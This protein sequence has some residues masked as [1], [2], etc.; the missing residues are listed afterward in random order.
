MSEGTPEKAFV[1]AMAAATAGKD[2]I[3]LEDSKESNLALKAAIV[4]DQTTIEPGQAARVVDGDENGYI[5]LYVPATITIDLGSAQTITSWRLAN[6]GTN[7]GLSDFTIKASI[8]GKEY[9][10]IASVE[11]NSDVIVNGTIAEPAAY[12]YYQLEC[13]KNYGS[14]GDIRELELNGHKQI[15]YPAGVKAD[16]QRPAA[17]LQEMPEKVTVDVYKRQRWSGVPR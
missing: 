13:V 12:R 4:A 17:Y 6:D 14:G 7:Y 9:T 1:D 3:I 10:T 8:D 15:I 2:D 5:R 16:G 11:G